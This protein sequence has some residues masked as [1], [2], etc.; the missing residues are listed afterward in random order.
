MPGRN[1]DLV[2]LVF[3]VPRHGRHRD[4]GV[5]RWLVVTPLRVYDTDATSAT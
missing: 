1:K 4:S 2:K 3:E 5:L